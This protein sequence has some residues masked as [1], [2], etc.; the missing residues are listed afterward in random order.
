MLQNVHIPRPARAQ[1]FWALVDATYFNLELW[2]QDTGPAWEKIVTGHSRLQRS[3]LAKEM[4][5]LEVMKLTPA[6]VTYLLGTPSLLC[7]LRAKRLRYLVTMVSAAPPALWAVLKCEKGWLG[8]VLEDLARLKEHSAGPW[9][10]VVPEAWPLWWHEIKDRPGKFK[11]Q[12][13]VA[14]RRSTVNSLPAEFLREADKAMQKEAMSQGRAGKRRQAADKYFCVV[15]QASFC[16][17]SN[18]ACHFRHV[19]IRRADH[20]HYA[21]GTQCCGCGKQHHTLG[22][23]LVHLKTVPTCW[24]AV[25]RAGLISDTPHAGEGSRLRLKETFDNPKL[26]PACPAEGPQLIYDDGDSEV[27]LPREKDV[28]L[29]VPVVGGEIEDWVRRS[30]ASHEAAARHQLWT[31]VRASLQPYPFYQSEFHEVLCRVLEDVVEL[32]PQVLHWPEDL[33]ELVVSCLKEWRSDLL[34]EAL[35]DDAAAADA[36]KRRGSTVVR[37]AVI[38]PVRCF[39]FEEADVVILI[40]D[41]FPELERTHFLAVCKCRRLRV[42]EY[43]WDLESFRKVDFSRVGA[44]HYNISCSWEA[45]DSLEV[46]H[47]WGTL[48]F[49]KWTD[50]SALWHAGLCRLFGHLLRL[51][52]KLLL[53]GRALGFHVDNKAHAVLNS[54]AFRRVG[55]EGQW[56]SWSLDGVRCWASSVSATARSLPEAWGLSFAS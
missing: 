30:A 28:L 25:R 55:A 20:L 8:R 10:E 3:I 15:C 45:R 1:L 21:G 44:V 33:Y 53:Q 54:D 35:I 56:S 52:W 36:E 43:G 17:P 41:S 2:Q 5:A 24:E 7:M 46:N 39:A 22:R 4:P 13:G 27:L 51:M 16:T 29:A 34:V 37:E 12:V 23:I 32:Q 47:G 19:H 50:E 40:G 49:Q 42:C 48:A 38:S 14:V 9:P 11:R 26:V 6:D 18:L 31:V